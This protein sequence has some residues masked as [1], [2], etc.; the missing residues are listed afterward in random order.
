MRRPAFTLT[1][2][3]V[4]IVVVG[5]LCG[6]AVVALAAVRS[7]AAVAE[8]A[9][10]LRQI[11][12]AVHGYHDTYRYFPSQRFIQ[13]ESWMFK[14][15]PFIDQTALHANGLSEDPT[16]F[17]GT[18]HTAISAYVCPVDEARLY[19][20][21]YWYSGFGYAMT[22]YLGVAGD[23][24]A[25]APNGI[26]G[27]DNLRAL[28]VANG[29]SNTLLVGER[30]PSPD[31]FWGWWAY[32]GYDNALW[33]IGDESTNPYRNWKE[34]AGPATFAAGALDNYCDAH[35]FW[36]LHWG[37]ANWLLGDGSVRWFDYSAAALIPA[38]A[39]IA[40]EE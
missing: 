8:C 28:D 4:V 25:K 1:E 33:A 12:L 7:A 36:S 23:N 32:G 38:M 16:I 2:L 10:K 14:V 35:H 20:G 22:S 11:G 29:L 21:V 9:A 19:P 31:L 5:T 34:C 40:N 26:L 27:P 18:W 17:G 39:R 37:G 24:S 6:F 3:L 15:L 13:R 30:P